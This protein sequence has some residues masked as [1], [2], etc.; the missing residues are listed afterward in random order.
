MEWEGAG[1]MPKNR[2]GDLVGAGPCP[3]L[4]PERVCYLFRNVWM[5][6][7]GQTN[8]VLMWP[9]FGLI[10]SRTGACCPVRNVY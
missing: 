8:R 9:D 10:L 2:G 1:Q 5:L 6:E 7:S 4:E 3:R